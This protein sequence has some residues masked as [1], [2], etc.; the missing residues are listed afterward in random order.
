VLFELALMC[1]R[2]RLRD[3]PTSSARF[4][5]V[6]SQ[7]RN[8]SSPKGWA[9]IT[10]YGITPLHKHSVHYQP[11]PSGRVEPGGGVTGSAGTDVSYS[12]RSATA[13]SANDP[14]TSAVPTKDCG[15]PET[16][17]R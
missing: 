3:N 13:L 17:S 6:R 5:P 9:T 12:N 14:A 16:S 1:C 15:Q 2:E 10:H 11:N 8:R 4:S 7:R